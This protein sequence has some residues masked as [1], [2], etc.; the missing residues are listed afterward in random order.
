MTTRADLYSIIDSLPDDQLEAARATLDALDVNGGEDPL[1]KLLREALEDDEPFTDEQR[2]A[3]EAAH[4]S[5]RCGEGLPWE[6][7][8]TGLEAQPNQAR[9]ALEAIDGD[10]EDPLLKALEAAPYDD[11]PYTDE[12]RR[13]VEAAEE[14]MDRG[15]WT[16]LATVRRSFESD[17]PS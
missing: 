16:D 5:D 14:R 13:A 9:A 7:V 17:R 10:N 4:E 15:E 11:E 8:K 12:Q 3:V 2:R 1:T 6:Q